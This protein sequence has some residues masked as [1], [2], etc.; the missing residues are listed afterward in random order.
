MYAHELKTI[1]GTYENAKYYLRKKKCF[2]SI[3]QNFKG[4][5]L[6]SGAFPDQKISKKLQEKRC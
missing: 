2:C 5:R 4:L 3:L 6:Y 1:S